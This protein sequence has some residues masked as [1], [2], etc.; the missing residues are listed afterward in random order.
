M[1]KPS[2]PPQS[3]KSSVPA[4]HPRQPTHRDILKTPV[5]KSR[6]RPSRS[7]A[8]KVAVDFRLHGL[9][10]PSS[11]SPSFHADFKPRDIGP[12]ARR[13]I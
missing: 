11:D 8:L 1:D 13:I 10:L 6:T 5:A 12:A 3:D 9:V 4:G 2:M 7:D